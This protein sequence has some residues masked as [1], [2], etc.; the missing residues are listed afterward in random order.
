MNRGLDRREFLGR[1][2]S[3]V[4]GALGATSVPAL[5]EACGGS[6]SSSPSAAGTVSAAWSD[7]VTKARSEGT[8]TFYASQAPATLTALSQAF[9]QQYPGIQ[10]NL[11]R[12][13]SAEVTQRIDAEQKNGITGA[14]G[15]IQTDSI[16]Q[17]SRT[18]QNY[19]VSLTGPSVL[20]SQVPASLRGP[21][22]QYAITNLAPFGY[23]WNSDAVSG[24]PKLT[25]I[26]LPKY[27]GRI[28]VL[29]YTTSTTL[30]LLVSLMGEQLTKQYGIPDPLTKIAAQNPKF[31]PSQVPLQQDLGAGEFDIASQAAA[32]SAPVGAPVKVAYPKKP[33]SLPVYAAATSWAKHPNAAQLVVDFLLSKKGQSIIGNM[34]VS[35]LPNIPEAVISASDVTLLDTS[36][37]DSNDVAAR[38]ANLKSIFHR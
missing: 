6:G 9:Q 33:L 5:L 3:L 22:N 10:A 8:V 21:N 16:F 35:A 15:L 34:Q 18:A 13:S 2:V 14:D 30:V 37:Y 17:K 25:D 12:L 19:F 27:K 1:G 11:L 31:Y 36:T 26:L 29:D 4:G 32:N 28:A 7:V 38:L 23:A 24:T 20:S